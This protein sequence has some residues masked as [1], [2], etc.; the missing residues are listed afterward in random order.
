RWRTAERVTR[1]SSSCVSRYNSIRT[2]H[3]HATIWKSCSR[4]RGDE[5]AMNRRNLCLV[6]M[7]CVGI[8][9]TAV[10]AQWINYRVPGVPRTADGKVN[11][12]APTPRTPDG[13]PDLSG[14]WL[15]GGGYFGNLAKDLK[16]GELLMLPWAE[17]QVK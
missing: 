13:R 4:R 14:T 1:P 7:L 3:R 16:A 9:A 15:D 5:D 2:T 12:V 8:G 6:T 17:A 10:R 11:L